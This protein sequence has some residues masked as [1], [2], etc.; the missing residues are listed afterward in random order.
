M[1]EKGIKQEKEQISSQNQLHECVCAV[2]TS[3]CVINN[4]KIDEIWGRIMD[5]C[6][7]WKGIGLKANYLQAGFGSTVYQLWLQRYLI[8]HR[9]Q[10]KIEESGLQAAK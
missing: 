1:S 10:C 9:G 6:P 3:M 7:D 4:K 5:I 8:I 2:C